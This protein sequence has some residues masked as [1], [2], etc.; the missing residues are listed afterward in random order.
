MAE[1]NELVYI[2]PRRGTETTMTHTIK[3]SLV[4]KEGEMF[5]EFPDDGIG[6]GPARVK[7]G[8]GVTP[9]AAL[10]YVLGNDAEY[11]AIHFLEEHSNYPQTLIDQ[12]ISGVTISVFAANTKRVLQLLLNKFDN[13]LPLAG[14]TISGNLSVSGNFNG[15]NVIVK[16]GTGSVGQTQLVTK[17]NQAE[18]ATV[19]LPDK[20]G[21]IA[22]ISDMP[23]ISDDYSS[24]STDG[25]SGIAVNKALQTLD[26]TGTSAIAASKTIKS[27]KETDG[28][29]NITTQDI[30]ITKSQISDFPTIGNGTLTIQRNGTDLQTF[31]ANQT[32]NT[33][34]NITV[35]TA[36]ADL[37]T[38]ATHRTVTDT[39]K[40]TW[41]NKSDLTL[42][43]T[44]STAYR[45]DRG[46]TAYTHATDSGRLTTATAVGLYKVGCTNQGHISGLTAVAKSDITGLGIPAAD[47][48]RAIKVNGTEL[49]GSGSG[50][51]AVNF[52]NGNNVTITGSG[53]DIT[54]S[55]PAD[56]NTHRPIKVEGTQILG[57]NDTPVNF[58]KGNNNVTISGDSSNGNITISTKDTT[59]TGTGLISINSSNEI[60]TTAE[61]NQNAFSYIRIGSTTVAADAKTDS[62]EYAASGILTITGDATND[63]VT[64]GVATGTTSATAAAGNHT[65]STSI[66]TDTSSSLSM[67]ANTK[68]KITAGG[69]SY[70]FT[71]PK[72]TT[73]SAATSSTAGLMSAADKIK[74]DGITTVTTTTDGLMSAADKTKLDGIETGA[75]VNPNAYN[76]LES[77]SGGHTYSAS[78]ITKNDRILLNGYNIDIQ[79]EPYLTTTTV[80]LFGLGLGSTSSTAAAGD[81]T[82]ELSIDPYTGNAEGL[83]LAGGDIPVFTDDTTIDLAASTVYKL[84][85]GGKDLLFKTPQDSYHVSMAE[86]ETMTASYYNVLFTTTADTRDFLNEGAQKSINLKFNPGLSKL[87]LNDFGR[88]SIQVSQSGFMIL[89]ANNTDEYRI[90]YGM[91][92]GGSWTFAPEHDGYIN[93]GA[94]G[95]KWGTVY[96]VN[97][98][99]NTSDRNLKKD[100]VDLDNKAK[101]FIMNLKPV[102]YKRKDGERT[103]YGMV[104]QDVEDTMSKLGMTA[105]DFAGLCKDQKYESY[106]EPILDEDGK[107]ILDIDGTVATEMKQRKIEGEYIYGLR[108]EEFIS[109][110]IYTIQEQ[111]KQIDSQQKQI[112]EL[113]AL[114]NQLLA[115]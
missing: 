53:N 88:G 5:I 91:F 99:I 112:D 62:V 81:H 56:T 100:I 9:Y 82:H 78:P 115:K 96:A 89:S 24:T 68:Y 15:K 52:K 37:T 93:L 22:L 95:Y 80:H 33:T 13:Y 12:I 75:E 31:T 46:K 19:T 49:L 109:P 66:T 26:V 94:S 57:N 51:G 6:K 108:Y 105:L 101:D 69:T 97:G 27:W 16:T 86:A 92:D 70:S 44:S 55:V 79:I 18:N 23:V 1:N 61:V 48:F 17:T 30:S 111:Q 87:L 29:V 36:L 40:T 104:A 90:M 25:M 67:T 106:R 72:D 54:I 59:Y 20:N 14:G 50:T 32:G 41:N 83:G 64:F 76:R 8:D 4:L 10:D 65:H 110:M 28:K 35:P 47:T 102:S 74:L 58:K 43:E 11:T 7:V 63:K 77:V 21:T 85:A 42:G 60:S 107:E 73:Y 71:T 2:R 84:T 98:T 38:D 113:K 3:S 45:G 114:V 34:A 39:E 103:H